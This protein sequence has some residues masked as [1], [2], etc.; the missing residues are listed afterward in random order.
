M[1]QSVNTF[2]VGIPVLAPLAGTI[3][4]V[5]TGLMTGLANALLMYAID[6]LIDWMLDKGTDFINVQIDTLQATAELGE[7]MVEQVELQFQL[8]ARYRMMVQL[9]QR[10]SVRFDQSTE[11]AQASVQHAQGA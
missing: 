3:T 2:I 4:P 11:A 5:L 10:I 8:S 6:S 9:N 1:E 7:R